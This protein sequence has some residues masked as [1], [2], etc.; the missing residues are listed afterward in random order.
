[1]LPKY[2]NFC[3]LKGEKI[4]TK[5]NK[6]KNEP[7]ISPTFFN[8]LKSDEPFHKESTIPSYTHKAPIINKISKNDNY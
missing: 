8:M 1:M 2:Y 7:D 3:L 5:I 4:Y 6:Q